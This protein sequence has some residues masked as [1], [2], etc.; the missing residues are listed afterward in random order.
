MKKQRRNHNLVILLRKEP[1]ANGSAA[2]IKRE[3]ANLL[4]VFFSIIILLLKDMGVLTEFVVFRV[5]W[6]EVPIVRLFSLNASD[7]LEELV[8]FKSY[9][10]TMCLITLLSTAVNQSSFNFF[11]RQLLQIPGFAIHLIL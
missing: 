1:L 2:L 4:I 11:L 10:I 3:K 9:V 7:A 6:H 8:L 5:L